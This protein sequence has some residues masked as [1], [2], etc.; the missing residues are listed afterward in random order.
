MT[1]DQLINTTS[2]TGFAFVTSIVLI[3]VTNFLIGEIITQLWKKAGDKQKEIK[4]V[5][6]LRNSQHS[7]IVGVIENIIY[8]LLLIAGRVEGIA[9]W[10]TFKTIPQIS[11]WK[12]LKTRDLY[13]I[14]IIG[15]GMSILNSI[16][17]YF[18]FLGIN[19]YNCNLILSGI[20]IY[21]LFL[22]VILGISS[23]WNGEM[24]SK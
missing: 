15:N 11:Y 14:F 23:L 4:N 16:L 2:N 22:L 21:G 3:F 18:V 19:N 20:G 24:K 17:I 8:F 6:K 13:N 1:I 5:L 9:V 10:L 7:F 12:D